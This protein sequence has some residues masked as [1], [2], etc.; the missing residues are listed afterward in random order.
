MLN[1]R[2]S[3]Y[4]GTVIAKLGFNNKFFYILKTGI[5]KML[6]PLLTI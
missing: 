3:K 6:T 2:R 1:G 4:Y 5:K